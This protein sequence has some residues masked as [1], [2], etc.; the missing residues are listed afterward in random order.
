VEAQHLGPGVLGVEPL[1]HDL[2]PQAPGRP[3]LGDFF[4]KIEM[5]VEKERQPGAELVHLQPRGNGRV[6]VGNAVG[7]GE[8]HFLHRGGTGLPDMVAADADGVPL[9][10]FSVQ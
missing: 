1:L 10:H 9:G 8:G 4:Q 2:G 3:E 6:H 5:R 7:Q